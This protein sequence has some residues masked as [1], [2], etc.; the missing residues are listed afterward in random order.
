MVSSV[1]GDA[2]PQSPQSPAQPA[3]DGAEL[4]RRMLMATEAA[5]MAASTAAQALLELKDKTSSSSSN[6]KAWYRLLPRPSVFDPDSREAELAQWR[7]WSWSVEQYLASIDP[8]FAVDLARIRKSSNAEVDMSIM[9]DSEKKRCTFL[10]GLYASLL[11]QR[12]LMM[13]KKIEGSNGFEVFRLLV[14]SMEPVSRNRSLGILNAIMSWPQFS[15]KGGSVVAQLLKSEAAFREYERTTGEALQE[16]LRFAVVFPCVTGQ[17]KTWLQLQVQDGTS[18]AD[19]REHIVRYDKATLK[20]TDAMCLASE[21]SHETV[22]MDVDRIEKGKK[23]KGKSK[24]MNNKGKQTKG[25]S[26]GD[27]K[28]KFQSSKAKGSQQQ[29]GKQNPGFRQWNQTGYQQAGGKQSVQNQIAGKQNDKG[30]GRTCYT[31]GRTG[32]LARDCWNAKGKGGCGTHSQVRSVEEGNG[33][34]GVSS[35]NDATAHENS[36]QFP[37]SI[38][39]NVRQVQQPVV[40]D[41]RSADLQFDSLNLEVRAVFFDMSQD[42]FLEEYMQPEDLPNHALREGIDLIEPCVEACKFD[43]FWEC[44]LAVSDSSTCS[45]TNL[46]NNSLRTDSVH[47]KIS[48]VSFGGIDL[49]CMGL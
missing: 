35:T 38:S 13:L 14:L 3:I 46:C 49:D 10:Y 5:S 25:D 44:D 29:G 36:Q 41:M 6:E 39:Q 42:D 7:E 32:H 45:T 20:W 1:G 37:S 43:S 21:P 8:E 16:E 9:D 15:M 24:G 11:R 17:L 47:E 33:D 2:S 26:K 34:A 30:K 4:A 40:F 23:G 28:V 19:L 27:G 18:Y 31:C 48:C 12:P 22:P